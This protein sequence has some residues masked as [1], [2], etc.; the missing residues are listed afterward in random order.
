MATIEELSL[1]GTGT[2]S[3][4]A[5]VRYSLSQL[6]ARND[7]HGFEHLCRAL[8]RQAITAN[9]L[10]ATGP[11]SAGG[12]QGRDFETFTGLLVRPAMPGAPEVQTHETAVF[13]CTLQARNL[14]T[15]IAADVAKV[16]AT[17]SVPDVI[18][19]FSEQDLPVAA[20]HRLIDQAR[21]DHGIRL[22]ILD[23]AAMSEMLAQREAFWIAVEHLDVPASLAPTPGEGRPEWY[24]ADRARWLARTEPAYTLGD[25]LDLSACLRYAWGTEQ[26]RPDIEFWLTHMMPYL[27]DDAD[28]R[29]RQAARYGVAVA[30]FRGLGDMRPADELVRALV[31]EACEDPTIPALSDASVALSYAQAAWL[32]AA[33]GLTANEVDELI[34]RLTTVVTNVVD[35]E[36]ADRLFLLDV[37]AR[38]LLLMDLPAMAAAGVQPQPIE[39]PPPERIQNWREWTS[40][41]DL[42]T[43]IVLRDPTGA[44]A[45]WQQLL[46]EF[47]GASTF[48]L[49]SLA[50]LMPLWTASL[51]DEP[52]WRRLTASIDAATERLS[53]AEAAANRALERADGLRAANM[54]LSALKELHQ[55]RTRLLTGDNVEMSA[56]ALLDAAHD[57]IQLGLGYAAKH[58]ALAAGAFVG[59]SNRPELEP[60][61]VDGLILAAQCDFLCGNWLSF[62]ALLGL[63]TSAHLELRENSSDLEEWNDLVMLVHNAFVVNRAGE[64][65]ADPAVR[66]AVAKGMAGAGLPTKEPEGGSGFWPGKGMDETQLRSLTEREIGQPLFADGGPKRVLTFAAR[67]VRWRLSCENT[68]DE[69]RAAERLAAALQVLIAAIDDE[70]PIYVPTVLDVIVNTAADASIHEPR[71]RQEGRRRWLVTLHRDA[72]PYS[73]DFAAAHNETLMAAVALLECVWAAPL[74]RLMHALGNAGQGLSLALVPNIRYDRAYAVISEETF[75]SGTRRALPQRS[76]DMFGEPLSAEDL[77]PR[78]DPGPG[79]SKEQGRERAAGRYAVYSISLRRTIPLLAADSGFQELLTL[80]RAQG[81]LDWHVL[82]AVGNLV[83]NRRLP[84]DAHLQDPAELAA[85]ARRPESDDIDL[86]PVADFDAQSLEFYLRASFA[87]TAVTWELNVRD[88]NPEEV[89]WLLARR[90]NYWTDDAPHDD[91]FAPP[92]A[93]DGRNAARQREGLDH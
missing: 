25:L 84:E 54:P 57:Y 55:A 31:H 6:S 11:V 21:A 79:Y 7:H 88:A 91:P 62:L 37:L 4:R 56:Q 30:R 74:D 16:C 24:E 81:W 42:R 41:R 36:V 64:V 1:P 75:D 47:P 35:N 3:A 46:D 85:Q 86:L 66:A 39:G 83:T 45:A 29:L 34:A 77:P 68:Y 13:C 18:F 33:T 58:H 2:A 20:R 92:A 60:M 69:V 50:H 49:L 63:A 40:G 52:G 28:P 65:S 22:E 53:G 48:P 26:T 14:P 9:V 23:G 51:V 73:I 27:G 12:D 32:H 43:G 19:V 71:L 93:A 15:K 61:A 38:L 67:G 89:E 80:L 10:P 70:D 82:Q 78:T 5:F 59:G 8:T 87:A 17:G 44:I 72:G 90:Y 76:D